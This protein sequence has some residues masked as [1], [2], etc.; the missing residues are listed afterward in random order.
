MWLRSRLDIRW[1]DLVFALSSCITPD[2]NTPGR[3]EELTAKIR[4]RWR[5]VENNGASEEAGIRENTLVTLSVRSGFDLLLRTLRL[6]AGSEI[7]FSAI[8]VPGMIQIAESHSLSVVPLDLDSSGHLDPDSLRRK[9]TDK[10]RIL[11]VAHLFGDRTPLDEV[12]EMLRGKDVLLVE[13]CAQL[14]SGTEDLVRPEG[15]V[16]LYSFGPIKTST[17]LGGG[18]VEVTNDRLASA[19]KEILRADPA[20][21]NRSFARRVARFALI[22][23]MTSRFPARVLMLTLNALGVSPD[24]LFVKVGRG[25]SGPDLLKQIRHQPSDAQLELLDRRLRSPDKK[26]LQR[27]VAN[28]RF[29]DQRLGMERYR[30]HKYW[31]YDV[32]LCEREEVIRR[33]RLIGLDAT[34][35]TRLTLVRSEGGDDTPGARWYW[36]HVVFVPCYAEISEQE[37]AMA[38]DILE[39]SMVVRRDNVLSHPVT[40]IQ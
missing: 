6:P 3:R 19:M 18:I 39:R 8:T 20:L 22:K 1:R 24:D 15:D 17:A 2:C 7:L 26:S 11:V 35:K 5:G 4:E 12:R 33:L 9:L 29:L 21:S 31:A 10:T 25:F 13:D 36:D 23:C 37:L 40:P 14:F 38:A 30:D 16:A 32:A 28:G 34:A 27:R